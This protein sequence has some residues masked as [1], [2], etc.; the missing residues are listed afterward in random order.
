LNWNFFVQSLRCFWLDL[1]PRKLDQWKCEFSGIKE[2]G[3]ELTMK[4]CRF[5]EEQIIG[6][7]KERD[8]G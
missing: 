3:G 5:T 4:R 6:I 2:P 8:A 1:P 7:L